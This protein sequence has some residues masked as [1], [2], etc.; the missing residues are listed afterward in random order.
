VNDLARIWS[1]LLGQRPASDCPGIIPYCCREAVLALLEE[2][3]PA[4]FMGVV[5][6]TLAKSDLDPFIAKLHQRAGS[7]YELRTMI[8]FTRSGIKKG[9]ELLAWQVYVPAPARII[10]RPRTHITTDTFSYIHTAR[11][12]EK[13]FLADLNRPDQFQ[14]TELMGYLL[15]SAIVFGGLIDQRWI[16]PWLE[17]VQS[18]QIRRNGSL[19]WLELE[20]EGK[21]G[22][23][24][25]AT[26]SR[27]WFADPL[28]S[29][30]LL[31]HVGN[32]KEIP[33]TIRPW[34]CLKAYFCQSA[35]KIDPPSASKIDPPQAVVFSV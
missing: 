16:P 21:N 15:F 2:N 14:A 23:R 22:L 31:K 12:L 20:R 24:M 34:S 4:L 29:A 3:L 35:L 33:S 11:H 13:L 9:N 32:L 8:N 1:E 18:G 19:L 6:V 7:S 30:L 10:M 26:V 5:G 17:A 27:R 28:T 25:K